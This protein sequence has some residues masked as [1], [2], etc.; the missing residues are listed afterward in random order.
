MRGQGQRQ[1]GSDQDSH[2]GDA[3]HDEWGNGGF[4]GR[5]RK[6]LILSN[7]NMVENDRQGSRI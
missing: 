6:G 7:V 4:D 2:L 5:E 1:M 3:D